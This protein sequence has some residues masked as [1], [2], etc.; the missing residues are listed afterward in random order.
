MI[1]GSAETV[2]TNEVGV[3]FAGR[4]GS[5]R[6]E[7]GVAASLGILRGPS[8]S[9]SAR[10]L[11]SSTFSKKLIAASRFVKQY[12]V[13]PSILFDDL[14]RWIKVRLLTMLIP[15]GGQVIRE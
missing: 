2:V 11:D 13:S 5:T 14:N 7:D 8:W 12:A 4:K 10:K 1:S 9:S 15:S 6:S 3:S